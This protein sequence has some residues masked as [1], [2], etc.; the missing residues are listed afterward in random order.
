MFIASILGVNEYTYLIPVTFLGLADF[1]SIEEVRGEETGS[2]LGVT[3][4]AA[5][6]RKESSQIACCSVR[7]A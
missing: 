2:L 6:C 4:S 1:S 7:G 3:A 5:S